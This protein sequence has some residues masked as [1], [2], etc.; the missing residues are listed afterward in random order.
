M[1]GYLNMGAGYENKV[2]VQ[3]TGSALLIC[4]V[5][6]VSRFCVHSQI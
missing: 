3:T 4:D 1:C 5:V 6:G 2:T